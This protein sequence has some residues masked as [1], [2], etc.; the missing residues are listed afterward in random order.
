MCC[1]KCGKELPIVNKKFELCFNCNFSRT[2]NGKTFYEHQLEKQKEFNEKQKAKSISRLSAK[3]FQPG[4]P[5][6]QQTAKESKVKSA[7]GQIK[8]DIRLEA[9]QNNEYFCKGCGCTGVL[10]CSHILSVSLHKDLELIKENMQLLCRPCHRIWESGH[11]S[12]R[13][14]LLCFE[15]N[16]S[17][18]RRYDE[19]TWRKMNNT[20]MEEL[21]SYFKII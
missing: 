3:P 16:L 15:D 13:M 20:K 7:L 19:D 11:I 14:E 18:M 10:D 4:K 6:K 1:S 12:E 8:Q 21:N 5:I 17:I 9:I 2:H